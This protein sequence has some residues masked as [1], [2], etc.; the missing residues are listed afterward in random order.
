MGISA[1]LRGGAGTVEIWE[2]EI[3]TCYPISPEVATF[4][5]PINKYLGEKLYRPKRTDLLWISNEG[6]ERQ[7]QQILQLQK[8][9]QKHYVNYE[10]VPCKATGVTPRTIRHCKTGETM[11]L[12]P[13][14]WSM[15]RPTGQIELKLSPWAPSRR[16]QYVR[17]L[18]QWSYR[19][20]SSV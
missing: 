1:F 20:S 8:A 12:H 15:I 5:K 9:Q 4:R 14:G 16:T 2:N 18:L 6:L 13:N 7:H 10:I 11:Y 19:Q 3:F 17:S